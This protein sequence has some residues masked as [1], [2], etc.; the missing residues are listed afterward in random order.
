MA[1]VILF[2][3]YMMDNFNVLIHVT[4]D[5]LRIAKVNTHIIYHFHIWHLK[6]HLQKEDTKCYNSLSEL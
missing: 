2:Q 4:V 6:L 5:L 3:P 1:K